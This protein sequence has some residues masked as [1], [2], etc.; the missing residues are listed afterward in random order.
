[1]EELIKCSRLVINNIAEL[2]ENPNFK[3]FTLI[4]SNLDHISP[5]DPLL[6]KLMQS[7]GIQIQ[8]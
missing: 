6:I 1:M 3:H 8:G 5:R 7:L 4:L 2:V